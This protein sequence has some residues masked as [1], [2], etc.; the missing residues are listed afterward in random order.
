MSCTLLVCLYL[1]GDA[2]GP[3]RAVRANNDGAAAY[4]RGDYALAEAHYRE[5]LR[6]S[7]SEPELR[8]TVH[9]NLAALYKR[10]FFY[11]EAALN[12][13]S[14]AALTRGSAREAI[15]LNNAGEVRW[16]QGEKGSAIRL[17]RR[18]LAIIE[19]QPPDRPLDLAAVLNNLGVALGE[20]GR[21]TEAH[22]MLERAL[23]IKRRLFP[24]THAQVELTKAN[25]RSLLKDIERVDP[26][27]PTIDVMQL[28]RTWRQ[29]R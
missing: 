4:G 28:R 10:R 19:L 29:K 26:G 15:S 20:Q 24:E 1:F 7:V 27:R 2:W 25:L 3:D 13:L 6:F 17:Y 16:L 5:A 9:T 14:A 11:E 21:H 8:A 18:A 23:A 12:Y 22:R